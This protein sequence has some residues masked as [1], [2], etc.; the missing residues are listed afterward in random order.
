MLQLKQQKS[1]PVLSDLLKIAFIIY[2]IYM[3]SWKLPLIFNSL[4]RFL[5][6]DF[7]L[8]VLFNATLNISS[9]RMPNGSQ[10][11]NMDPVYTQLKGSVRM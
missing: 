6:M 11:E 10:L 8:E 4:G 1:L 3:A 5:I 7:I 2:R 9:A